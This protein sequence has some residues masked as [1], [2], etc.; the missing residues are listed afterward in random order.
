MRLCLALL[1]ASWMLPAQ[2][3]T[4]WL[5]RGV[6]AF[7]SANYGE[8]VEAFGR[9]VE[10]NPGSVTARLY[11][12]TAHMQQYIPGSE[13]AEVTAHADRAAAEFQR[14]LEIEPGNKVALSSIASLQLNRKRFTEARDW[15]RKLLVVAPADKT[16]YYSIA[17]TIWAEWYPA[18]GAARSRIGMR[19][20]TPGPIPDAMVRDTLRA[21]WWSAIDEGIVNLK[22]ALDLDPEYADAMAYLNLFIRERADLLA[23]KAEYDQEIAEADRWVQRALEAKRKQANAVRG[24]SMVPPPPPPPP[25]PGSGSAVP[26]RIAISGPQSPKLIAKVDPVYPDMARQAGIQ[27]VVKFSAIID[28]EG[29]IANL[30]VNSGHPLLIPAAL[31]AV[32]QWRFEPTLLNGEPVQVRTDLAVNFALGN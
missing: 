6:Q 18:Y 5:N 24:G 32:K 22:R 4:E 16:A 31:D 26:Q 8:A 30:E 21:Q 19:P 17:F 10:L 14:V 12:G 1:L 11:L 15:Y 13:A 29:R 23:G 28:K 25:P 27:G 3:E 9:A 20:E 7:K 2:T